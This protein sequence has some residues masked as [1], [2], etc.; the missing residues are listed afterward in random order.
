MPDDLAKLN[1]V[2]KN[3]AVEISDYNA[4]I[5]ELNNKI[6]DVTNFASKS[7]VT[8]LVKDLDDRI[9]KIDLSSLASKSS[10]NNYMLTT[11]FN[12]TSTELEKK[13]SD[14]DAKITNAKNALNGYAKKSE[15]ANDIT[16][17][18][19]DYVPTASLTS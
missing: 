5:T 9:Y 17:I 1:N 6:P 16:N 19:N 10:L 14:N 7:S 12:S 2:V 3:D 15:V 8:T 13:I 18:K 11:T 4:K